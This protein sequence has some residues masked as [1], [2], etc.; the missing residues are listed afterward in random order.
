[1][2]QSAIT[3]VGGNAPSNS[4]SGETPSGKNLARMDWPAG[5]GL[6]AR[7]HGIHAEVPAADDVI[8]AG[9]NLFALVEPDAKKPFIALATK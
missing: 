4:P 7:I 1:M 3:M 9:D 8:E 6:V 5:F 2:K